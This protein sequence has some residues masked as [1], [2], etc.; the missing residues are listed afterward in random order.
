[1][2]SGSMDRPKAFKVFVG[3]NNGREGSKEK[4]EMTTFAVSQL[5]N[6]EGFRTH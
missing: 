6:K 2:I 1:M 3:L 5:A 4:E